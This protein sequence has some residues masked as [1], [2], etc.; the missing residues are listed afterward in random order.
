MHP[1]CDVADAGSGVEPGAQRP[2]RAVARGHG[3]RG[4][5][6]GCT[7]ELAAL[8]EH[9]LV[10][11]RGHCSHAL[12]LKHPNAKCDE[13]QSQHPSH[14]HRFIQEHESNKQDEAYLDCRDQGR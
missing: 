10:N 5:S 14:G 1:H 3:A 7:E 8:V 6:Y 2:E 4:E 11:H 9:A 13:D 12:S